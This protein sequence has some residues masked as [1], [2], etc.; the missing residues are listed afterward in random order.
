MLDATEEFYSRRS[1][2]KGTQAGS[3]AGV[4]D[5][6][7]H[8]Y[9][10]P[11]RSSRIS[12][13][14]V[15]HAFGAEHHA[16]RSGYASDRDMPILAA[17]EVIKR[18]GSAFM[19]AAINPNDPMGDYPE[20]SDY[21]VG[22]ERRNSRPSSVHGNTLHRH[23]SRDE[24]LGEIEEYDPLFPEDDDGKPRPKKTQTRR[25]DSAAMH[26][27]PSRDVWEDEPDSLRYSAEVSTPDIDRER[28]SVDPADAAPSAVFETPEAELRRREQ[29]PDDMTSDK[30][31]FM[32]PHFKAGVREQMH[33]RPGLPR[34]PSSDVWEDSPDSDLL[35]TTVSGPQRDDSEIA[36]SPV[37][38]AAPASF[39]ADNGG[40]PEKHSPLAQEVTPETLD[41]AQKSRPNIPARPVRASHPA[42]AEDQ[43]SAPTQKA[44]PAV[45]ARP[46]SDKFGNALRGNAG[47]LSDLNNRL[48]LGPQGPP[49]RNTA[50]EADSEPAAAAAAEPLADARKGRAKGPMRRKPATATTTELKSASFA[51][52]PLITVWSIDEEDE[53]QV[54]ESSSTGA[55]SAAATTSL[56]QAQALEG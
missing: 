56:A 19:H 12:V 46:S 40:R 7:M 43:S 32:K 35:E 23:T 31:T 6:V 2:P 9:S 21:T 20:D 37:G 36:E 25:P 42:T 13:G 53:L 55:G 10:N 16:D 4:D 27:F 17:D 28:E 38:T 51:L 52:S 44:K 22:G 49:P 1:A 8:V 47:F 3:E 30:K 54:E 45:P 5:H 41:G 24:H 39:H 15:E 18:P 34:F 26:H 50:Q 48:K 33:D 29:N 11:R 14:S